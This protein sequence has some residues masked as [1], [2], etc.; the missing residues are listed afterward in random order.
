MGISIICTA[1]YME[2]NV[3]SCSKNELL[4]LCLLGSSCHASHCVGECLEGIGSVSSSDTSVAIIA[5]RER[6][7]EGGRGEGERR[8]KGKNGQNRFEKPKHLVYD[9][10]VNTQMLHVLLN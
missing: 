8:G 7:K 5:W 10:Y 3:L 9:V 1:V 4:S 6:G 2:T